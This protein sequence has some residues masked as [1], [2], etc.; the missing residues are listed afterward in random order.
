MKT[1]LTLEE[2][3]Q[4]QSVAFRAHSMVSSILMDLEGGAVDGIPE[5]ML[6]LEG[7]LYD[8]KTVLDITPPTTKE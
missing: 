1:D 3:K 5:L 7:F 4:A 8:L 6:R 2:R